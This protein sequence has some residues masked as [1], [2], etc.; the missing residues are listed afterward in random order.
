M[1]RRTQC[2][3]ILCSQCALAVNYAAVCGKSGGV[4]YVCAFLC[5]LWLVSQLCNYAPWP[6][7]V[8]LMSN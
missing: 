5:N 1:K 6:L 4:K 8:I 2:V 3:L 7:L